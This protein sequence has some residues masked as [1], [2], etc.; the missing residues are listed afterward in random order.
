MPN[1][2]S[3]TDNRLWRFGMSSAI[4]QNW[5]LLRGLS[6]ETGHWGEFLPR[7]QSRFPSAQISTLDLPGTGQH[8]RLTSPCRITEIM[9]FVRQQALE[10][11]LLNQPLTIVSL[12]LG[13]MVSWEWMLKHPD[14][15]CAAAL[16]NTS[17]ASLS[18]FYQRLRW[19]SY[20]DF[21]K[22]LLQ[23]DPFRRESAILKCI[24]NRRDQDQEIAAEW[25][26]IQAQRPVGM[27]NTFRQIT[28]AARYRPKDIK[29]KPAILLLTGRCD[30]F[31][32]P[33]CTD[34]I[35]NK[36][37]IQQQN[38]PWGGHDLTYDDGA[39]VADRLQDWVEQLRRE[40]K[41]I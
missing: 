15:I 11:G 28:A 35:H 26:N 29:P 38:H 9:E 40:S 14:E 4:G 25:A 8:Y 21:F 33:A 23:T 13:A 39:W 5:L 27:A 6:R 32:S 10:Q 17:L 18:P 20:P 2:L 41:I 22:L 19:Q 31:V 12:S 34:A 7:L 3:L 30:R 1:S 36:W 24:A 16:I 37:H